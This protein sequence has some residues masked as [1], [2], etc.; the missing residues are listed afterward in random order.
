VSWN[1]V[2]LGDV[3]SLQNG[4]AFKSSEYSEEGYFLMRITNVQQGFIQN[5]NP[6]FVRIPINSKLEQFI[7]NEGDILISLT[8]DVG[9]VGILKE[10]NLPAA[11]NQRVARVTIKSSLKLDKSYLFNLLNSEEIRRKIESHGHGAA[12]LNVSTKDILSIEIP[13][14]P[15]ATQQKIVVKLDAIFA[16][17]D[18]ATIAAEANAK[19]AEALFQSYLSEIFEHSGEDWRELRV[20]DLGKVVTGNTPK[21]NEPEN[22]GEYIPFVKPGDFNSDGTIDFEKQ[23]LSQIGMSKSRVI[24]ENSA[25]MVCI[26]AT[27]GKCGFSEIDIVT[28]QQINSVTP[29]LDFNHKF[30]YLQMLTNDFQRKVMDGS[31]QATLPIINKS[32]WESLLMKIPPLKIQLDIVERLDRLRFDTDNLKNSQ[33]KKLQ[34]LLS[35]K[36]SILKQAFNGDLV[37]E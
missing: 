14:P 32:K 34:Q 1:T 22:Y 7:L 10:E 16:E 20:K 24:K 17:I 33:L 6:K 21:T 2:T 4:Y 31:G 30:I 8:G 19:N 28:N 23:K 15:I 37:K 13:L 12:Q 36:N 3:I 5:N 26:G 11:L 18:K 29:T 9:R 27:I 35:L 25:L